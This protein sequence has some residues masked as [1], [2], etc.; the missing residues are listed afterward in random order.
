MLHDSILQGRQILVRQDKEGGGH[1]SAAGASSVYVGNVRSRRSP[2]PPRLPPPPSPSVPSQLPW[3]VE[4]QQLKDMCKAH[5]E[6]V[7]ADVAKGT[8]GR[9]RGYGVVT[10]SSADDAARAISAS[11]ATDARVRR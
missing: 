11:I 10:F 8:D 3:E 9:S 7:F 2:P 6:V 1:G 5:G 4:W